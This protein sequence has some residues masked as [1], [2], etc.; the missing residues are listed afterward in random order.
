M[1][2]HVAL[3]TRVEDAEACV[4]FFALLGFARVE[5]PETLSDR[6]V[7]MA[8]GDQQI[9]LLLTDEPDV[10]PRGHV[11]VVLDDYDAALTRLLV[12]GYDVEPRQQ[13]WGSPRA[14]VRDSPGH[15]VELMKFPPPSS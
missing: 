5:P 4:A 7:W 13:H 9:H 2:H 15:V 12:A 1:L 6:A 3:E 10:P 8:F 14:F 11:A